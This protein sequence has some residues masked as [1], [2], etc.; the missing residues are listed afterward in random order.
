MTVNI[1]IPMTPTIPPAVG[2]TIVPHTGRTTV[3]DMIEYL[4][5]F[6]GADP[7]GE[8]DRVAKRAIQNGLRRVANAHNWTYLYNHG[9]LDTNGFYTTGTIQYQ[10]SSG[11][12][13]YQVTLTG[14]TFPAWT[15]FGTFRIGL[16][17]YDVDR[18]ISPTV[19]T[20]NPVQAATADMAPGTAFTLYRDTYTMPADFV[21]A[22]EGF[23]DVSWGS[24]EYV[25]PNVWLRTNRYYQSY[26]NTPRYYTFMGDPKVPDRLCM[27]IFPYPDQDRTIDL[28]YKRRQRAVTL[29][30]YEV[31]RVSIDSVNA[32]QTVIGA[33][34]SWAASMV[35][36]VLRVS[37]NAQPP[38]GFSGVNPAALERNIALF[39]TSGNMSFDDVSPTTFTNAIYRISDPIDIEDGAMLECFMRACELEIAIERRMKDLP[40][41]RK[42]YSDYLVAAKEADARVFAARVAGVGG[43]YRQRMAR[44]PSGPDI[45]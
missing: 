23:A 41:I 10:V 39:V 34:T 25:H 9:R 8:A 14:G 7:S 36:S 16:V 5:D 37:S 42:F 15:A 27:R 31:G 13:P 3:M 29:D 24:M 4:R 40:V 1:T 19:C 21:A 12:Y 22:D 30:K 32:P 26:S 44:M 18:F 38:T 33:G 45:P 11:T 35:G 2:S 6:M 28:I 20:L 43:P 17:T